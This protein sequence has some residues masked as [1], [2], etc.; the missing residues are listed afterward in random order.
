MAAS[1]A[2]H[3]RFTIFA[4]SISLH[5]HGPRMHACAAYRPCSSIV[6]IFG[7]LALAVAVCR[8]SVSAPADV[9]ADAVGRLGVLG[10]FV[11]WLVLLLMVVVG[12]LGD[13]RCIIDYMSILDY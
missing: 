13:E 5:I 8:S 12:A 7:H 10:R 2:P 4:S 3:G 11:W 6:A 9:T 1:C